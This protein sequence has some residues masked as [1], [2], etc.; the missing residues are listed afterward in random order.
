MVRG[1]A[2]CA[3]DVNMFLCVRQY[4]RELFCCCV[5]DNIIIIM[6]KKKFVVDEGGKQR[7]GRKIHVC[8]RIQ[9]GERLVYNIETIISGLK[10]LKYSQIFCRLHFVPNC[11][12][13]K[14]RARSVRSTLNFALFLVIEKA[15]C[16]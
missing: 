13:F 15:T 9:K 5:V 6:Y 16:V 11:E 1:W 8:M 3:F 4:A 7:R 14:P 10:A 12:G 2:L